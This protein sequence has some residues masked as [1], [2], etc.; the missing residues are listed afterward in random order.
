[1]ALTNAALKAS[2]LAFETAEAFDPNPSH[3]LHIAEL[4]L[5]IFD[6]LAAVHGYGPNERRLLEIAARLH[7]IGWSIGLGA[8]HHKQSARIIRKSS[9]PGLDEKDREVC[10]LTARFHT[11]SIPDAK[12][13]RRFAELDDER[14]ERRS[15]DGKDLVEWLA[16]ILRVADG[17]DS[18]HKKSVR[19]ISCEVTIKTVRLHLDSPRN[20]CRKEIERAMKKHALLVKKTNRDIEYLCL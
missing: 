4:S 9:I 13:H 8:G 6:G 2:P 17:L 12:R 3:S 19:S 16:G 11:K 15:G 5:V 1:M 14:K 20:D 10:A 18:R 7:D